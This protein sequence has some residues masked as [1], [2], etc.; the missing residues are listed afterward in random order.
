MK[1]SKLN[2]FM[3]EKRAF[4][5]QRNNDLDTSNFLPIPKGD[6]KCLNGPISDDVN[7]N[8]R[9]SSLVMKE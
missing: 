4:C 3:N 9:K 8:N 7:I 2:S 5:P 6:Y 1:N